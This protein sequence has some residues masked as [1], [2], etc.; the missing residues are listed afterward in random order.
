V[1][2]IARRTVAFLRKRFR[3]AG[4]AARAAQE[5]A[6]MKST[7]RFHGVPM[8]VLRAVVRELCDAR[9]AL[10]RN[11]AIAIMKAV[12]ATD[13]FDL[14]TAGLVLLE[15]KHALLVPGDADWL[16]SL[17]RVSACWAHVDYL[18]TTILGGLVERHPPLLRR[19]PVWA[20]GDDFWVRRTALLAQLGML[21]R[22][23]GDFDLFAKLAAPMLE[24]REFFIR[25]AIGWVL[26]E[27]SKKRPRLV[28]GFLRKH[29]SRASGL[30]WRE[31]TKYLPREMRRELER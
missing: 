10:T 3:A 17:V 21:R 13:Y 25:K 7:L 27:V 30:T 24:E 6:Y 29:G 1:S 31:A 18:A 23:Q 5:K 9:P 22:G 26:R 2:P 11:D 8:P 4:N 16:V 28:L 19:L 20:K 12:Y 14:R 15:R